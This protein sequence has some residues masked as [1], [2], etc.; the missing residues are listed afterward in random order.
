M[1][2]TWMRNVPRPI[3]T[4]WVQFITKQKVEM[5]IN[6]QNP[7]QSGTL[8]FYIQEADGTKNK[9]QPFPAL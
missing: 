7:K 8:F 1:K 9:M 6:T 3:F 5:P 4:S 2:Q